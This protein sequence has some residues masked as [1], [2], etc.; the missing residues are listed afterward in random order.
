[1]T[2]VEERNASG[3]MAQAR[4]AMIDSQ[5]RVS[6]VNDPA[7]LAAFDSVARED[8]VPPAR[9][10]V[11][12]VD[13]AVPLADGAVLAPALSHGQMLTAAQVQARDRVL[14]V[15]KPGDYLAALVRAMGA[16]VVT[17]A[18]GSTDFAE[19]HYSLILVDGAIE[20]LPSAFGAALV[21]D[22]RIVTG[23]LERGVT[24]LALGRKVGG[25]I[26]LTS[27]AEADFALLP[28]YAEPAKWS[29]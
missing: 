11:A 24:R 2:L 17:A 23:L 4:R 7:V 3:A 9:A 19:P 26:V 22:G 28:E 8:F 6:G 16:S 14:V 10:A 29:F 25:E 15:G 18:A 1:M 20:A 21:D 13:R 12:Y 27:L 5:L